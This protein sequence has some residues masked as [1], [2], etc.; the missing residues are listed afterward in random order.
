MG[1]FNRDAQKSRLRVFKGIT[2]PD[3]LCSITDFGIQSDLQTD[4]IQK[5]GTDDFGLHLDSAENFDL[6]KT[7]QPISSE[8]EVMTTNESFTSD[9]VNSDSQQQMTPSS[10]KWESNCHE[11]SLFSNSNFF[12]ECQKMTSLKEDDD[13]WLQF[14]T[15]LFQNEMSQ[16]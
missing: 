16:E 10:S 6:L 13:I 7:I 12:N 2:S 15:S 8:N 5:N 11:F 9:H 1:K 4:L 3:K 14:E